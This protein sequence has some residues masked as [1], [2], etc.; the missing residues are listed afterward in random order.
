MIGASDFEVVHTGFSIKN[1]VCVC[2]CVCVYVC[3]YAYVC[4]GGGGGGQG[5]PQ[6]ETI[7]QDL[8]SS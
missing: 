5:G 1:F 4:V 3:V 6:N 7:H 2:V 8:S